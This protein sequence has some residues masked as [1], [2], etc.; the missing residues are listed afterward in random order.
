MSF[1]AF[2]RIMAL[3]TTLVAGDLVQWSRASV[4]T[5]VVLMRKR[6]HH[7]VLWPLAYT[8]VGQLD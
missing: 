1:S 5:H 4:G 2:V 6:R 7:V 3:L 8:G